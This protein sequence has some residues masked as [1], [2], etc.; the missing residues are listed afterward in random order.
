M[1][2]VK[3]KAEAPTSTSS[4][5][6][7]TNSPASSSRIP[8]QTAVYMNDTD[9]NDDFDD[10]EN[11]LDS[12]LN[13]TGSAALPD[14]DENDDDGDDDDDDGDDDDDDGDD[15]D[16]DEDED[17]E[18]D[19]D[20]DES[21]G[22]S[23][24]EIELASEKDETESDDDEEEEE[25]DQT[26]RD[27]MAIMSDEDM[28]GGFQDLEAASDNDND[29]AAFISDN[30]TASPSRKPT[31]SALYAIPT[32]AEVQGLKETGELFKD[33]VF[34]LKVDEML[35]EVRPPYKKA[36]ALELV[37]RRL[38][39]LF[40]SLS[41]ITPLPVAEAIKGFQKHTK[42]SRVRI[43]FPDPAPKPDANYKL[44]FE[45]PFAMHLVGSWPLKS[46]A[47]RPEG[48][49]I[50]IAAIMPS[51]LFQQKDYV[52]FRYFHKKAFY[53]AA[54][55][56]AI[57][58]AEDEHEMHLGVTTSFALVDA[59]P[60][61]PILVLRPIHD[62]SET[63]FSKLK[64]TIR[65]HPS[66]EADTFK[67]I[68][69]GPLR[70]NVRVAS[71]VEAVPPTDATSATPR[72]N[73]AI[74]AD[75]LHLS[76]LVYLHTVSQA[77]PAFADACLLLKTWAF[78]RGFGSGARSKYVDQDRRRLVA[79]T[80]SLRFILTMILAH[81][82]QGEEKKPGWK[83]DTTNAGRSK[84][85]NSFSS[86]Q[87]FRGVMDWLAKHDFK[88]NPVFMKSMPEAGLASRSDKVPRQDFSKAFDRVMVDPSG[89]LNLFAFVPTGSVDLLQHEARRTF[90]MLNDPTSDHFDALFLQD[91]TAAPFTFDEVARI[92]LPLSSSAKSHRKGTEVGVF[93]ST[94]IQRADFGTSFQ[95]AMIQVS[96]TATRALKGRTKLVA[97]LH[98]AAGGLA[99]TWRL[100]GSRPA[101]LSDAEIGLVLDNEQAWRMVEHGPSSQDAEKAEAFRAFW[102]KLSELRRFKDGRVLESVVWP[103]TTQ[104]SRW[105]I[106]RRILAYALYRH[107]AIH[108]SQ[109]SFVSP[110]F[111]S[112]LEIDATL[113]RTAHLVS[114]EE[115]GFTL[116]QSAFDQLSKDL[117]ALESLPL[118]IIAISPASPGL[119]GTSTF[120]PAPINLE[121][122][123]TRI[124]DAASYLPVHDIIITFEGSG[125]W[126]NEL[127]AIQAMKA[128]FLERICAEISNKLS[129]TTARVVFDPDARSKM[130]DQCSLEL[131]LASGFAFR[132]RVM[133]NREKVLLERIL[134]DR[135][136]SPAAKRRA[137][138]ILHEWQSRFETLALHHS[139]IGSMGHRFASFSSAVRLT[140]RWLSSQMLSSPAIPE[141][142]IEL[143]CAAAYLSPEEGAPASAVAGLL[144]ILRLLAN[145]RWKEEPLMVSIQAVIDSA[146]AKDIYIFPADKRT[147]VENHFN[148]ARGS[149]PGMTHRAW[150]VATETDLEGMAFGRKG[151]V[152]GI[153]DGVKKLAKAAV[154]VL[155]EATNLGSDEV[156][157]LFTPSLEH[158]DFV[159][160][161]KPQVLSR[162]AE[163]VHADLQV[164]GGKK[165][166]YANEALAAA[167]A[168]VATALGS[169]PKPGFDPAE[170]FLGLLRGLYSD[171]FRLYHDKHGGTVI[172]GLFNPSL[173]RER[174]FKVGLGFNSNP[175]E[176]KGKHPQ[177]RLNRIAV[178]AEIERLGEGLVE[179][180]ELRNA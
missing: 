119:R 108:E 105:A 88:A 132:A 76:H 14:D 155:E 37:L 44:G 50:D 104:A 19:E 63:D 161:L 58:T 152:G 34:K 24:D 8:K 82:L 127:S 126:P 91:R 75:T 94:P 81:L 113:S 133:H 98:P 89:T 158:Y 62:K 178:M 176:E 140:K 116:V 103:V 128:A 153:A 110:H 79:G 175:E 172:G 40:E 137:R 144:R 160:H 45:K 102:G 73:A 61:R 145:W 16:D 129:G 69:L 131:I 9:N 163:N 170:A 52:N 74:L 134:A 147:E 31:K 87:L 33:N 85:A 118:S 1:T 96:A 49:D 154:S 72:Y 156:L 109:I 7:H 32:L 95:A 171:S 11:L 67:P 2:G 5:S 146:D 174:S 53:L 38:H 47:K 159:I 46:T 149:D 123:G 60:R 100:D 54:L 27:K 39:Q 106:P 43:P 51:N 30:T 121:L 17:E 173:D 148:A 114:T 36:S 162:Y 168:P 56:H 142:L 84:L 99:G 141:E 107:H 13:G 3:R 135:F 12:A 136:E 83:R 130:E 115:K 41:P 165:T 122:L 6:K 157:A 42:R 29:D 68:H 65:I 59:D 169:E 71:T 111:D 143:V 35:P 21:D 28:D 10:A 92:D 138:K 150:F 23:Q 78:Q 117:R 151:P 112:L 15:D 93:T 80:A 177:V 57:H 120:V 18:E 101:A 166:K 125:K 20:V 77:C 70:S 86:Y 4:S 179:K 124:P 48:T 66:V 167:A 139:Y 22:A 64:C 25:Y 90:E 26:G 164:W 180:V 97:L 55:A